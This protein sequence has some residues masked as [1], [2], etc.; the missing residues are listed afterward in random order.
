MPCRLA[1]IMLC[2]IWFHNDM[3]SSSFLHMKPLICNFIVSGKNGILGISFGLGQTLNFTWAKPTY[4]F[5][6]PKCVKFAWS[7]QTLDWSGWKKLTTRSNDFGEDSGF[8]ENLH[9]VWLNAKCEGR[10]LTQSQSSGVL[11]TCARREEQLS[12]SKC[13]QPNLTRSSAVLHMSKL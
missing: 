11:H 4:S 1:T 12:W 7:S 6:Q 5:S 9:L 2:D 8:N 13:N 10:R 3:F